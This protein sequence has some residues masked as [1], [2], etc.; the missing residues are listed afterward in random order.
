MIIVDS[1]EALRREVS[2]KKRKLYIR[3]EPNILDL[4]PSA[5]R[6][7]NI[8]SF[9]DQK[10]KPECIQE[11][12]QVAAEYNALIKFANDR[13]QWFSRQDNPISSILS[14]P[15][16]E[17]RR[18]RL[19]FYFQKHIP[20]W[21]DVNMERISTFAQHHG[22]PTRLIDFTENLGIALYF[23][24][25]RALEKIV[26]KLKSG[27]T[28]WE[29]DM[30][31]IWT[32][33][34]EKLDIAE[35]HTSIPLKVFKPHEG[36]ENA[37]AQEAVLSSW[38]KYAPYDGPV[39]TRPLDVLC[40]EHGAPSLL[41]RFAIPYTECAKTL[42]ELHDS[43]ITGQYLFQNGSGREKHKNDLENLAKFHYLTR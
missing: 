25:Y 39:D 19:K 34:K 4:V 11:F 15:N 22:T 23:A 32:L 41:T 14:I 26:N 5:L 38:V 2:S 28:D 40:K 31:A 3:G 33:D 27:K 42:E 18:E 16:E 10:A 6:E 37:K 24:T 9:H 17:E 36:N 1:V 8:K 13:P 7:G 29:K 30:M 35:K 43:G 20:S 12:E 21:L